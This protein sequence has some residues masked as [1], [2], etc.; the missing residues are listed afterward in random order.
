[1]LN[2]LANNKLSLAVIVVIIV[3]LAALVAFQVST[4]RKAHSSFDN[5]YTFRG[6]T[7][8]IKKTPTYGTCRTA[9]GKTITIVLY[10]G[11]WYLQG[12]LLTSFWGRLN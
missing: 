12:D 3:V 1:M 9:S 7:Q 4:L 2:R 8:L 10:Q 6:C 11:R 5:Y